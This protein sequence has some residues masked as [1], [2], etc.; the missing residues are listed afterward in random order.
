MQSH[1]H[2]YMYKYHTSISGFIG[3]TW[4][5]WLR[6]HSISLPFRTSWSETDLPIA[7]L[8]SG[9]FCWREIQVSVTYRGGRAFLCCYHR[10][11]ESQNHRVI[12]WHGL[13]WFLKA[14]LPDLAAQGPIQP[15]LEHLW[16]GASTAFLDSLH[17]C[18][19][20]FWGKNFFLTTNINLPFFF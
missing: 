9:C 4:V 1:F 17:L 16:D 7:V 14:E 13:E 10:N 5:K 20:T 12:E 18:L 3:L 6:L 11:I 15:D 19:T 8:T 2:V